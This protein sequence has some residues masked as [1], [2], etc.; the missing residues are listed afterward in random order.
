MFNVQSTTAGTEPRAITDPRDLPRHLCE[1]P[2]ALGPAARRFPMRVTPPF[3]ARIETPGDALARQVIPDPKELEDPCQN[4]DPLD[5]E[6]QSPTPLIVHRYPR[7]VLFLVSNRCAVHCRFC[8]RKRRVGRWHP[9]TGDAL[10]AGIQYI[11][12]QSKINEVILSGG[13]PLMLDNGTLADLLDMLH[14]LPHVR[15]LRLHTRIPC[16][17]PERL[18]SD[19]IHL[20]SSFQPLYIN[21]H[22]NHP[23][24]INSAVIQGCAQLADAGIPLGSQ[25]VLLKGINDDDRILLALFDK[26]LAI[27][28]RPYYLHQIDRV[29]GTAH[30]QVPLKKA[31]TLLKRLHS[32]LSGIGMPHF[33][34]DLPKGGGKI[35]LLPESVLAKE[36]HQWRVQNFQGRPFRLPLF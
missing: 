22:F 13:D 23:Q 9:V 4:E 30:F 32:R 29:P 33:M 1:N 11:R 16:V 20:L 12:T 5:E 24:E 36:K 18:T 14:K 31:L 35:E 8:M 27:R 15:I 17:W 3:L 25:T 2:D 34:V 21:V 7:R 28:V 6:T 19:L 26:L 10:E